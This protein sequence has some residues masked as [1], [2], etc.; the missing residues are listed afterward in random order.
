MSRGTR[1]DRAPADLLGRLPAHL[2]RRVTIV[3]SHTGGEQTRVV[4]GG[5]AAMDGDAREKRRLLAGDHDQLRRYI[6]FEP[7]GHRDLVGAWVSPTPVPGAACAIVFM[8]AGRYPYACGTAIVGAVTTLV[9]L[10]LAEPDADTGALRLDTPGGPVD[11]FV[12]RDGDRVSAV[13]FELVAAVLPRPAPAPVLGRAPIEADVVF[14]GGALA[15]VSTD[16]LDVAIMPARAGELARLGEAILAAAHHGWSVTHPVTGEPATVDGVVFYDPSGHA[17]HRGSGA[18]MY[19]A[20][21][22]DR[23]PCGTGTAAKMALLYRRGEL[24]LEDRFENRGITGTCFA[25]EPVADET[26]GTTPALRVRIRAT[27][28]ITGIGV[29][30]ADADRDPFAG[31][32]LFGTDGDGAP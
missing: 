2:G 19:G 13:A 10:G 21:H 23:S 7:R 24:A 29:L 30:C 11:T 31:G 12:E 16:Q 28:H 20:A 4:L 1:F 3:D 14:V 17:E 18:V 26:L 15:L 27:A 25:G 8:D 22:I 32:F 9:E 5:V 6:A